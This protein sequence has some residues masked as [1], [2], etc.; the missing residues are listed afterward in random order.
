[1]KR[2]ALSHM[3]LKQLTERFIFQESIRNSMYPRKTMNPTSDALKYGQINQRQS[4]M[5]SS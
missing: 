4:G 2:E 3:I 1:M 5:D